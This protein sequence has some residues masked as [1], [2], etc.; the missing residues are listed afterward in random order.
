MPTTYELDQP[1]RL[2]RTRSWGALT[3]DEVRTM[4][5][6]LMIDPGFDRSFRQ[7]CDLREVTQIKVTVETLRM[8]AQRRIFAPGAQRA[9]VVGREVDYGLSRLFQAYSEVEGAVVEVFRGWD[10]AEAWL[11]LSGSADLSASSPVAGT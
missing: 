6:R 2:V 4:Y 7:L 9:F 5:E 1:L 10:E 3:D 11:G 8:L